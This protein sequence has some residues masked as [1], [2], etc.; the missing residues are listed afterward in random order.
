MSFHPRTALIALT[1][2]A[3]IAP[4]AGAQAAALSTPSATTDR[5]ASADV[6]PAADNLSHVRRATLCLINVERKA[7][8]LKPLRFNRSLAKAANG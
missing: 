3:A 5:C 8:G 6:L 7:R 4:A 1:A 2:A